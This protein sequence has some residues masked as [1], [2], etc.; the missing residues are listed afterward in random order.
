MDR[1]V[2]EKQIYID[3]DEIRLQ[4]DACLQ[5][6]SIRKQEIADVN[7]KWY[8]NPNLGDSDKQVIDF[9]KSYKIKNVESIQF[10]KHFSETWYFSPLPKEFHVKCL[11]ICDFC[12]SFFINKQE[13]LRHSRKCEVRHPPGDEIYRDGTIAFFEVDGAL[14][15]NYCENLCYICRMYLEHKQLDYAL[16]HFLF[17]IL[18]E[19]KEDGFHLVGYFSKHKTAM[20]VVPKPERQNLSCILTMPFY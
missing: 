17:Y 12:L 13:Y 6:D 8:N 16:I 11:Y 4:K 15:G 1:W 3:E 9:E 18:C 20:A 7:R 10:G 5:Q 2:T 14:Q 19:I